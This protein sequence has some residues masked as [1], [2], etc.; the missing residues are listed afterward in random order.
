[1]IWTLRSDSNYL[2]ILV[3]IFK[4]MVKKISWKSICE[5]LHFACIGLVAPEDPLKVA[6]GAKQSVYLGGPL[7]TVIVC[8]LVIFIFSLLLNCERCGL[9]CHFHL[10]A[11]HN[12]L[13]DLFYFL[14]NLL[15]IIDH[16]LWS[17]NSPDRVVLVKVYAMAHWLVEFGL[18][19][20]STCHTYYTQV[21]FLWCVKPYMISFREAIRP[22]TLMRCYWCVGPDCYADLKTMVVKNFD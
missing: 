2:V 13:S 19:L 17:H 9:P 22:N 11:L 3:L 1:M 7:V 16:E 5:R 14:L 12:T 8:H 4:C 10:H 6:V 15:Y 20:L 21:F 18:D